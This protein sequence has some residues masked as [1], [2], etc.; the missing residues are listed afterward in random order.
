MSTAL[1]A[2]V[3][4]YYHLYSRPFSYE[5]QYCVDNHDNDDGNDMVKCDYQWSEGI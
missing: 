2:D 4:I 1:F 3:W 5:I